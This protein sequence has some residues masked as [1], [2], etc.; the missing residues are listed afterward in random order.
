[1]P[2]RHAGAAGHSPP[3]CPGCQLPATARS[4]RAQQAWRCWARRGCSGRHKAAPR[5]RRVKPCPRAGITCS[6]TRVQAVGRVAGWAEPQA[7]RPAHQGS[8]HCVGVASL[9]GQRHGEA[10]QPQQPCRLRPN[11]ASARGGAARVR[12]GR[13]CRVCQGRG[14]GGCQG[15]LSGAGQGL[16]QQLPR[17]SC[18]AAA[19]RPRRHPPRWRMCQTAG[20]PCLWL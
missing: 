13:G 2:R 7:L 12:G 4:H 6:E 1:M 5:V 14:G 19:P 11:A 20:P 16:A 17:R 8:Q 18:C 10:G 3:S 9:G 15:R